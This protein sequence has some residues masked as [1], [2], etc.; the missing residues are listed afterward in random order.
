M[1]NDDVMDLSEGDERAPEG[2]SSGGSGFDPSVAIGL[3]IAFGGIIAGLYIEGSSIGKYVGYPVSMSPGAI[4]LGG[5][6][7]VTIVSCGLAAFKNLPNT[8]MRSMKYKTMDRPQAIGQL[9][10]FAEKA[11]REGLL[12]LEDDLRTT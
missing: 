9:V 6:F 5:T 3:V 1:A 10:R 4:V 7:G 8:F 12:V 2:S 11:R